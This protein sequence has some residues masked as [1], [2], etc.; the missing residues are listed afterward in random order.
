MAA[1]HSLDTY[2][3]ELIGDP[4]EIEIF[5]KINAKLEIDQ[6]ASADDNQHYVSVHNDKIYQLK[7]YPFSSELARASTLAKVINEKG[8]VSSAQLF[9]KGAPEIIAKLCRTDTLPRNLMTVH[10]KLTKKGYRILALAHR[11]FDM[12]LHKIIRL[13]RDEVECDLMFL[14]LLVKGSLFINYCLPGNF[15]QIT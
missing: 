6:T 8:L 10:D 5:E 2:N 7:Q 4:L 1:C 12:Q 3:N 13:K 9:T 11:E 14:G 15:V